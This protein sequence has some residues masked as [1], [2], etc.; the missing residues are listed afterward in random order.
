[1]AK[2]IA[3]SIVGTSPGRPKLDF[4]PTPAYVT[5][6]L[7][8]VEEFD[9]HIWEPACGDGAITSVLEHKFGKTVYSSDIHD[10]CKKY[11]VRDFMSYECL[12]YYHSD[13]MY[14]VYLHN[15]IITNPPFKLA[16]EFLQHGLDLGAKKIALFLKL[17]FLEG[18]KR[19]LVLE[20]T[21]LKNIYVF[22]KRVTL[23]RNGEKM[24]N[25]GMIAFAWYVW[26]VGYDGKPMVNWI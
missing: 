10:Y 17:A 18:Q 25:S 16:L 23:T 22:R 2:N 24:K 6:A 12:P 5:E 13:V 11:I 15:T 20:Q 21:P 19:T 14:S 4:Y 9:D 8:E 26:E 1:M 7:L 3:Q